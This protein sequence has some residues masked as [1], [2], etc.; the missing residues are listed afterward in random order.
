MELLVLLLVIILVILAYQYWIL[1]QKYQ[2]LDRRTDEIARHRF[3]S[4]RDRE[5]QKIREE[6]QEVAHRTAQAEL[7]EW[8]G[9][10]EAQI[11]QDA[12]QRSQ[13]VILGK[14]TEHFIPYLPDFGYN[15][16]DARFIGSPIDFIVFD[17]IS[18]GELRRIVFVEVKTGESGLHTRQRS[19]REA[20]CAGRVEWR[21]VRRPRIAYDTASID[22]IQSR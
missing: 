15:P 16:K 1:Y 13:S 9:Q 17:G 10:V 21:E 2:L 18:T 11:R 6:E 3:E 12:V 8:K 19:I 4:W 22:K 14:V 7:R 20:I 5:I